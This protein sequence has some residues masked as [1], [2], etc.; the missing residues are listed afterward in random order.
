MAPSSK[1]PV[2][3]V[4]QLRE[5]G[6][7]DNLIAEELKKKGYSMQLVTMAISEADASGDSGMGGMPQ[8][9]ASGGMGGY[10]SGYPGSA[11]SAGGGFGGG[12]PQSYNGPTAP[13]A[14]S[15][16]QDNIYE[17]IEG[18]VET[19]I[20][21]R[22]DELIGEVKKIIE[23][24]EKMEEA[25]KKAQGDLDK[26]KEDFKLLHQGV[27]GKLEDYDSRMRDV[28]TELKAVGKVF[29]DV[30]PQFVDNVKELSS[31]TKGMKKKGE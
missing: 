1:I 5:Q 8:A 2:S 10:G 30:V 29:K 20:D 25:Q 24:K 18:T 26:L 17:R 19:M 23:W 28:D 15:S 21:E 3:E 7:T 27:L 12:Y 11:P 16:E 9:P 14:S 4:L 22:W 31:I 6:L 13:P